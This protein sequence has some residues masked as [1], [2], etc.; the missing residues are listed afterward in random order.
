VFVTV[1]SVWG[2]M[3]GHH[4][5]HRFIVSS[6]VRRWDE[7]LSAFHYYMADQFMTVRFYEL[8]QK[9]DIIAAE[10]KT[11]RL[12]LRKA[13]KALPRWYRRDN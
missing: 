8:E 1:D 11:I 5:P 4:G 3:E 9:P 7:E 2:M 13:E 10:R 6:Y 12:R